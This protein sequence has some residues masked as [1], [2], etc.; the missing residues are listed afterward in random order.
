M[1]RSLHAHW[2][3]KIVTP[4]WLAACVA[5]HALVA[6]PQPLAV[7]YPSWTL[8]ESTQGSRAEQAGRDLS[9]SFCK[10]ASQGLAGQL[11]V[12]RTSAIDSAP[13]SAPVLGQSPT[14][15]TGRVDQPQ[16]SCDSSRVVGPSEPCSPVLSREGSDMDM[17]SLAT[18]ASTRQTHEAGASATVLDDESIA[19]LASQLQL[20]EREM[21]E[22]PPEQGPLATSRA[23][24][25]ADASSRPGCRPISSLQP[26][27]Q[28][29]RRHPLELKPLNMASRGAGE[30][31]PTK[32]GASAV[33]HESLPA[34][35]RAR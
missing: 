10:A 35:M 18:L 26:R 14:E 15:P 2:G 5:A 4:A 8:S 20:A 11:E 19:W 7:L 25:G 32:T 24:C 33:L 1:A 31:A 16:A 29:Y 27:A 12:A 13:T 17:A 21:P 6:P 28:T 22:A 3:L 23:G 30:G 34:E 9:E